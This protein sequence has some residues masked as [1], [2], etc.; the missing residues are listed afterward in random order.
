MAGKTKETFP[1]YHELALP[2]FL[3]TAEDP[4][5]IVL[6]IWFRPKATGKGVSI[7]V[8][9]SEAKVL[10]AA[11]AAAMAACKTHFGDKTQVYFGAPFQKQIEVFQL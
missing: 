3:Y 11:S 2:M 1:V 8:S 6:P 5:T 7:G 4:A 9:F 10:E